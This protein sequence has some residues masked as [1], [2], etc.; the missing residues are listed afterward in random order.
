MF[1]PTH[2][3]H[4]GTI[5]ADLYAVLLVVWIGGELA[6]AGRSLWRRDA[7]VEDR[8]SLVVVLGSVFAGFAL[9]SALASAVPAA[10][11]HRGADSVFLLGL[12]LMAAG[13]VLRFTAVIVLGRYFTP[14]VM[15]GGDQHVVDTGPY[16][17]IRHPSYTGSLL[18]IAGVL[19]ASTNWFALAGLLPVLAGVLY[20]IR[21]EEQALTGQLGDAYRSYMRRT[22]R[23]VPFVY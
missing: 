15:V 10:D 19:L 1:T 22:K 4:A 23:L 13:I 18:T 8:G 12:L 17:W 21:V 11:I 16:R 6:I 14:V 9:G 20:R 7:R 2:A 3:V 5:A